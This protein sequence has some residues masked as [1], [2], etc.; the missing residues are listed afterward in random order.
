MAQVAVIGGGCAGL[1]AAARL[2]EGGVRVTLFE[3]ARQLGGRAR[4]VRW[5]GVTLDNG[6][7]ILLGA[8]RESLALLRL[9]GTAEDQVLLRRP[10]ELNVLPDFELRVGARLPAPAHLLWGLFTA[11]GLSAGERYRISR[12]ILRMRRRGFRLPHDQPLAA[13]LRAEAQSGNPTR[14]LWAP[15]CLA[16]LNTP[17]EEASAQVFLHV[18]RDSFARSRSDSDLLLPTADLTRLL[19][20]PLADY[21]RSHG[22]RIETATGVDA[23]THDDGLFTLTT[24]T[25]SADGFSHV[26]IATPPFRVAAL[27]RQLPELQAVADQCQAMR[28]QPIST[29]Y[30]QYDENVRLERPMLGLTQGMAQ[31]V[32]D[33]GRLYGQHGLLAVVIS[34]ARPH[35]KLTQAELAQ[36]IAQELNL[37]LPGLPAPRWHKVITEKR[38]TFACTAGVA[39]PQNTTAIP[40]LLLAGDYTADDYPATIE[41]A[42]RSGTR[43]A[44]SILNEAREPR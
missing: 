39:R 4:H 20:A 32:F 1:A 10:L 27:T 41:A 28:Y 2:A 18:L 24:A 3:A 22:G 26:I 25:G 8:Y 40:G 12:F 19:V 36:Q 6:Q 7:H 11:K 31:W 16:A 30:L 21:I 43:C 42:F 23:I 33:R 5:N 34:T 13:L 15:L 14:L 35:L 29:I 44:R 37:A 17:L 38:A 9:A